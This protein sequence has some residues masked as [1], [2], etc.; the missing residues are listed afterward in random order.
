MLLE[1]TVSRQYWSVWG[2]TMHDLKEMADACDTLHPFQ[3]QLAAPIVADPAATSNLYK[4]L[5]AQAAKAG[6]TLTA[7]PGGYTLSRWSH[8][9]QGSRTVQPLQ[10]V[11]VVV[12][13][14]MQ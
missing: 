2:F 5:Q 7:V 8:S 13:G 4:S 10:D 3:T 12:L 1:T 11:A 14:E 9:N 6:H